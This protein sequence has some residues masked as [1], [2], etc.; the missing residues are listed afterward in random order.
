MSDP[1]TNMR[2]MHKNMFLYHVF[3][4]CAQLPA[5]CSELKTKTC[6]ERYTDPPLRDI[7]RFS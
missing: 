7:L 2:L 3:A 1:Y 4:H 6:L 5:T